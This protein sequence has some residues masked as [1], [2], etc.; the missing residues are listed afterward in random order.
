MK[1]QRQERG[2][3]FKEQIA[4]ELSGAAGPSPSEE[5]VH[6]RRLDM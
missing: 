6:E 2:V 4:V 3:I 1:V 5:E